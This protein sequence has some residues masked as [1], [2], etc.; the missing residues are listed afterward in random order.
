MFTTFLILGGIVIAVLIASVLVM[1]VGQKKANLRDAEENAAQPEPQPEPAEAK[2][3]EPVAEEPE[4]QPEPEPEPEEEPAEEPEE[5]L[6]SEEEADEPE[7]DGGA[8]L[9]GAAAGVAGVAVVAAVATEGDAEGYDRRG[10]IMY[11]KEMTPGMRLMVGC[12]N[13]IYDERQY[14]VTFSYSF[15]ARLALADE[16]ARQFYHD[17]VEEVSHYKRVKLRESR[18]QMRIGIGRDRIGVIYFKGQKLCIAFALSPE[19][20]DYES[21]KIK[22]ISDKARFAETPA[23]LC[24]TSGLKCR[25][26]KKLLALLAEKY[27]VERREEPYYETEMPDDKDRDALYRSEDI[28]IYATL[29]ARAPAE[30]ND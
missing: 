3:P 1:T 6:G 26:A 30:E 24:L 28:K 5:E 17:F 19:E 29:V 21:M 27:G 25:R 14:R 23:M 22:D 4:P 11:A 13:P 9:A 7:D 18:R 16:N 2:E 20:V 12:L 10:K 15:K 8:A